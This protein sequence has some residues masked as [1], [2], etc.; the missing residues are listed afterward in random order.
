[1]VEKSVRISCNKEAA[2]KN[3]IEMEET[4]RES[5]YMV[6]I[7]KKEMLI[8]PYSKTVDPQTTSRTNLEDD[9]LIENKHGKHNPHIRRKRGD[10]H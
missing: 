3:E 1:M 6:K 4:T 2:V 9:M 10:E 5:S 8:T 7:D